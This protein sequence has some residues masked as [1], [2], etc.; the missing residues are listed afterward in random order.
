MQIPDV[1]MIAV[2][3]DPFDRAYSNFGHLWCDGLEPEADF[4]TACRLEP[5]RIAAGYAPFWRYLETGLYGRQLEH[6]YGIFPRKQIFVLR[7][8]QLI[9]NTA[10]ILNE[11]TA[12]LGVRTALV[13]TIPR[14]N[15]SNWVPD[16]PVNRILQRAARFGALASGRSPAATGVAPGAEAAAGRP[17]PGWASSSWATRG[18][19]QDPVALLRIGH[20]V[21][22]SAHRGRLLGLAERNWAR[23]FTERQSQG[24]EARDPKP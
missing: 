10:S 19:A 21:A 8:R 9:D 18:A 20:R 12:F 15:V 24:P 5:S 17:A 1:K 7:Y 3:R 13:S 14:S 23:A 2:I 4:L 6:L 22:R 11:I 16:S